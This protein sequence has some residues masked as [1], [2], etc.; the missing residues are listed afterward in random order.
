MQQPKPYI[1]KEV[2][3]KIVQYSQGLLSRLTIGSQKQQQKP[4]NS[5]IIAFISIQS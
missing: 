4:G 1:F 5:G 2:R 3:G